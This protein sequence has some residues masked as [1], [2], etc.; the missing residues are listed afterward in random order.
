MPACKSQGL[1][2]LLPEWPLRGLVQATGDQG[3]GGTHRPGDGG[4]RAQGAVL[5]EAFGYQAPSCLPPAPLEAPLGS[6]DPGIVGREGLLTGFHSTPSSRRS[7]HGGSETMGLLPGHTAREG[8]RSRWNPVL[9]PGARAPCS[10]VTP[11][12]PCACGWRVPGT[13]PRGP[14]RLRSA[15]VACGGHWP[16]RGGRG[17]RWARGLP[18]AGCWPGSFAPRQAC[19]VT[20]CHS[21]WFTKQGGGRH[22][23]RRPGASCRDKNNPCRPG[24]RP[25]FHGR[26]RGLAG[27]TG[28]GAGGMLSLSVHVVSGANG[29][30]EDAHSFTRP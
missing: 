15:L 24:S 30:S 28:P 5:L 4:D 26:A 9:E 3:S 13:G 6:S 1:A 25:G 16:C 18:Q 21:A 12:L 2:F 20:F 23:K 10:P 29:P 22:N 14:S 19:A 27:D 8:Q 17:G 7:G 11:Q